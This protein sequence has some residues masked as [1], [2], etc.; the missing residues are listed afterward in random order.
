MRI[1]CVLVFLLIKVERNGLL[2][3]KEKQPK[4]KHKSKLNSF[5]CT[6]KSEKYYKLLEQQSGRVSERGAKKKIINLNI[7]YIKLQR[8]HHMERKKRT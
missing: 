4:K 5:P 2:F 1:H 6:N 8:T 3:M 7:L